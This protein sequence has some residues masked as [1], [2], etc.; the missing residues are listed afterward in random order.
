MILSLHAEVLD[1]EM[2][3]LHIQTVFFRVSKILDV[4]W[5]WLKIARLQLDNP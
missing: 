5:I 2:L 3:I 4:K 1:S